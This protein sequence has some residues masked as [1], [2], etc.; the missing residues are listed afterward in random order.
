MEQQ[1][2]NS[3]QNE[4][5]WLE[6]LINIRFQNYFGAETEPKQKL[7]A[8]PN[9]DHDDTIFARFIKHYELNALERLAIILAISPQ[10]LPK[11]L[12]P[13]F[14]QNV[15][16][17]R[18]YTEFG[19][20]NSNN[21][22]GFI[23]TGETLFFLAGE[24]SVFTKMQVL[25][26]FRADHLFSN[27]AILKLNPVQDFEPVL[28]GTLEFSTE[29][30]DLFIFGKASEPSFSLKFPA[31][32]VETNLE[33]KDFITD[34][35]VMLHINDILLWLKHNH[36]IL[37]DWQLDK[38][39][40]PGYRALFYGP[41]GTGKTFAASL[42]GKTTG[43][44]VYKVDLSMV[45]SKW[46]GETEKNLAKI[47]DM[48]ENKDWILFFDEA[49]ALFGKRSNTQ[50]SQER[51]ANQE[52]AYLLQRTEEYPGT[53]I[54]ASNLKGNMDDAFSRR[55]QSLVY[56]PVPKAKQ[57]LDIWK[58]YTSKSLFL[59]ETIDLKAI[60][61][62]YEI[63]GGGIVNVIKYCAIHAAEQAN[64]VFDLEILKEGIRKEQIKEGKLS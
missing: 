31:T 43:R 57:R 62:E 29:F 39:I 8:P 26:L 21:H 40:K 41:P 56:F 28:S 49:D 24:S 46:V 61:E 9:L 52:V 12:D 4:L 36:T 15:N 27:H 13:F 59:P 50:S 20:V 16:Y 18:G 19:G 32:K 1:N 34:E 7:P 17:K 63:T 11:I 23:P 35:N 53:I 22:S 60:A 3:L 48:A 2:A 37:V 30:M 47:F 45:V 64:K 44:A 55:F 33:W 54:L 14:I 38:I 10:L 6:N 5:K 51:Y 42:I 25:K 58:N